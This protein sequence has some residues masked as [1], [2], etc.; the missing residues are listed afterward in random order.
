MERALGAVRA[1]PWGRGI[2]PRSGWI[3][4]LTSPT[5]YVL[6]ASLVVTLWAKARIAGELDSPVATLAW[7]IAGDVV[8][9]MGFAALFAVGEGRSPYV[10]LATYPLAGLIGTVAVINAWYLS[11]TGEQLT[12]E[13]V[14]LGIDRFADLWNI[15]GEAV[16]ANPG[17]LALA[18]LVLVGFPALVR[19]GLH[20][21]TGP[22]DRR[23]RGL[24]RGHA[25]GLVAAGGLLLAIVTPSPSSLD[26]AALGNNAAL[27][28]YWTWVTAPADER[29]VPEG[30]FAGYQPP[31]TVR[32]D[33]LR[34]L[35]DRT[36]RPNVLFVVLESTRYDHTSLADKSV[37]RGTR[38]PH[39]AALAERGLWTDRAYAVLPHTTKSMFSML[40]G[41]YPTMQRTVVEV[42]APLLIQCLPSIVRAAGYRTAFFQSSWGT[43]EHRPRLVDKFGFAE[44]FAWEDIQGEPLGYLASDD[45]S[46]APAVAAWLDRAAPQPAGVPGGGAPQ[47]F[48]AM[49][50]T[51]APHHP[52][53]LPSAAS[54]RAAAAGDPVGTD[55]ER[56][57]RLIEAS[58]H[59]LGALVEALSARG[60]LDN[61]IVFVSGDHG[62]GF[63]EKGVRQH[64]N[65][66]FEEGLRVPLVFAGPGVPKRRLAGPVS[67][68]DVMPTF[69]GLLGVEPAPEVAPQLIGTDLRGP[70]PADRVL[71]WSCWFEYRCRGLITGTDKVV[72]SP[73]EKAAY[74][75][76]LASDP[77]ETQPGDVP[78]RLQALMP[79]MNEALDAHR[80][81]TFPL[82]LGPLSRDFGAWTCPPRAP[83]TH[84]R[85]QQ[86]R[87]G[88]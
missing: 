26:A 85:A 84:P 77:R 16:R 43:F 53:R 9:Y 64:D 3:R 13:A 88:H 60:L 17:K 10:R 71:Y 14:S 32:P 28:L 12:W 39:L 72:Y 20:R 55:E 52:Y 73:E 2:P 79:G 46:L 58:D 27:N 59:M 35:A 87:F 86:M 11:I 49:V 6:L 48:F 38:T 41:R 51:S 76:D 29:A 19:I 80:T 21:V 36:D 63:G 45:E 7:A 62:E 69:L 44:F 5:S 40:C 4:L 22:R 54:E 74:H 34:A 61:T 67:L 70:V 75:F 65:N 30:T 83:C 57:A 42:S 23:A 47:P 56:Y 18:A 78:P 37:A 8:V 15:A 25:A 68:G 81:Y 66:V 50:L 24:E 31:Y 1:V 33:Q 82:E